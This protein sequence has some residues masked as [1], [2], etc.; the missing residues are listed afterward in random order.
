VAWQLQAIQEAVVSDLAALDS[1]GASHSRW[2]NTDMADPYW[3]GKLIA[4]VARLALIA[5]EVDMTDVVRD[6]HTVRTLGKRDVR[7]FQCSRP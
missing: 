4:M 7:E 2:N 3:G 1:I 6:P 5:D